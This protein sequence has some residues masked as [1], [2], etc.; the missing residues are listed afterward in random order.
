M[1]R[2]FTRFTRFVLWRTGLGRKVAA[3]F[4]KVHN[5]DSG[6]QYLLHNQEDI[7]ANLPTEF[8]DADFSN[9]LVEDSAKWSTQT[10]YVISFDDV[11]IEPERLLGTSGL[12]E[13]LEHTVVFKH[14]RQYPY[15]L[16]HLL[17]RYSAKP[18]EKA[19]LYD[20][21]ATRNYYHHFVD[22]LSS[23]TVWD[24]T[25]LPHDLPL[26][27][28]RY[29]Y[30]QPYFQYLYKKSQQFRSLN[31]YVVEPKEWLKVGKLY[32]MQA[33]HFGKNTWQQM[34]KMYELPEKKPHRKVFLNRDRRLYGRYLAN[35][36]EVNAMLQR[37]GF[38][39][40][41]A[42]HLSID[43]QATL[44]QE[45]EY[46]VALHGAGLV[47]MFFMNPQFSQIIEVMPSNYLMPLYYWQAYAMGMRYYD[48][49][50][51]GNMNNGKEYPVDVAKLEAAVVRMLSNTSVTQVYG[52]TQMPV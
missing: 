27:V 42:E 17:N 28:N 40:V 10:E 18:I 44:F 31:W 26:L 1:E 24:K 4:W 16:P 2:M 13:L 20:G 49:V 30:E 35:E 37:H 14:D 29:V 46:M 50:V 5:A 51:G 9:F 21:S 45:T 6:N 34:R 22:A 47:Q 48:V 7:F 33:M 15:I 43:E 12:N 8:D 23:L 11:V 19:V 25:D 52:K 38:E 41:L 39:T 32:K 36:E 3:K